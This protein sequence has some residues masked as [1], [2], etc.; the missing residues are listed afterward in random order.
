NL[1]NDLFQ[2][3][4]PS[5]L[6]EVIVVDD[7]SA[8][9]TAEIVSSF[10]NKNLRLLQLKN[11]ISEDELSSSFKKKALEIGIQYATGDLIITTDADCRM[12]LNWLATIV[13]F[14]EEKR[15]N[16]IVAPVL[17]KDEKAFLQKF[18]F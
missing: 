7:F 12:N 14:F 9:R 10:Q 18:Q 16:M 2:Q 8:D 3:D 15:C 4:F 5:E 17:I 1:L 11:F 13:N 6:F